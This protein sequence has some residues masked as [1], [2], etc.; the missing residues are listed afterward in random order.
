MQ[1]FPH[2]TQQSAHPLL[3]SL[4]CVMRENT[5]YNGGNIQ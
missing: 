4:L 5:E 1:I 2:S 3:R